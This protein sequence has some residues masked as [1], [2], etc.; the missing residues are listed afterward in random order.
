MTFPS[1]PVGNSTSAATTPATGSL[2]FNTT[3]NLLEVYTGT[4]WIAAAASSPRTWQDWFDYYIGARGTIPDRYTKQVYIQQ[5][6]QGRFPGNYRVDLAGD[7]W[8]MV[9]DSPEDETWF[10]LKYA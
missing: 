4:V 8:V 3:S 6:M 5:E 9:F 2:R 1:I 10:N 7:D